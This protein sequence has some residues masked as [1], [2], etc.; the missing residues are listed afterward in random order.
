MQQQGRPPL[1][2]GLHDDMP[3]GAPAAQIALGTMQVDIPALPRLA[4]DILCQLQG[5][6]DQERGI[7]CKRCQCLCIQ[8]FGMV[9]RYRNGYRWLP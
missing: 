5:S 8:G 2:N 9:G 3:A 1:L 6:A 4:S 7:R